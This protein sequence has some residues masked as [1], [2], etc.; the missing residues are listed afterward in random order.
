MPANVITH[1]KTG[2]EVISKA[3]G[4]CSLHPCGGTGRW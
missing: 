2:Y 4:L 3:Y 1:Y